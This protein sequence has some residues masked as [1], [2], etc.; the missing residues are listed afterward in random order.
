MMLKKR[1][2]Y[3]GGLSTLLLSL[4]VSAGGDMLQS[5][6][7]DCSQDS[8]Y[9]PSN[10]STAGTVIPPKITEVIARHVKTWRTGNDIIVKFQVRYTTT[11]SKRLDLPEPNLREVPVCAKVEGQLSCKPLE[12]NAIV[13][14]TR[15]YQKG[16]Q[17]QIAPACDK[18]GSVVS[19]LTGEG[20]QVVDIVKSYTEDNE[21]VL[22]FH[23]SRARYGDSET[24]EYVGDAAR[25]LFNMHLNRINEN[26]GD[27]PQLLN[28]IWNLCQYN[29]DL[30]PEDIWGCASS[31]SKMADQSCA[32]MSDQMSSKGLAPVFI[33]K[34]DASQA[35]C[36]TQA[37]CSSDAN[38]APLVQ[39]GEPAPVEKVRKHSSHRSKNV[40]EL[41]SKFGK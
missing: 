28:D 7:Q 13:D 39:K 40:A 9:I 15:L 11:T 5:A 35:S 18:N 23:M 17:I 30:G 27:R 25:Q 2:A 36:A 34:G 16:D 6:Q 1:L 21:L 12:L 3:C 41:S 10:C 33:G 24:R 26:C 19:S 8:R 38:Q 32:Q 22:E 37:T 4:N 31:V 29:G 20:A 14:T